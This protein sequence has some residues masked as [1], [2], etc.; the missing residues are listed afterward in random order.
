MP[1]ARRYAKLLIK[2]GSKHGLDPYL[3]AALIHKESKWNP[4]AVSQQNYGLMQLRVSKTIHA[5]Y[6]GREQKFFNPA[7]NI[8]LGARLLSMWRKYCQKRCKQK[9]CGHHWWSHYQ[10]GCMV[11]TSNS[12]NRVWKEY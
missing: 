3:L 11:K 6:L 7:L 2:N 1:T 5:R 4:R 10:W 12:G 9:P 8:K